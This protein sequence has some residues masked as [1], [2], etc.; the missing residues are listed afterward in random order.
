MNQSHFSNPL[1]QAWS[2]PM[3]GVPPLDQVTPNHLREALEESLLQA[4]TE[5]HDLIQLDTAGNFEDSILPLDSLA[6]NL[7]RVRALYATNK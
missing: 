3:G 7:H 2:G 5:L 1:S 6:E 4:Q